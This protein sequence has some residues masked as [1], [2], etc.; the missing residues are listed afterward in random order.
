[1]K[2]TV[3]FDKDKA[4]DKFHTGWGVSY[5]IDGKVL[6][7]AGERGDFILNNLKYLNIDTGRITRVVISHN[8]WD[9]H[10]G[11]LDLLN[12]NGDIA[13]F[14]CADFYRAYKSKFP[15]YNFKLVEGLQEIEKNIYTTG[16][17]STPYKGSSLSEQALILRTNKGISL[18]CGCSHPGVWE[19][20]NKVKLE[21]GSETIYSV[22][23]GFHLM[24]KDKRVVNYLAQELKQAG[25]KNVGPAHCT[26]FEAVNIFKSVFAGNVL[27]VKVGLEINL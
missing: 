8:H 10:S 15:E 22:L 16:C 19:F 7:D 12:L 20:V 25:V 5:L 1:M 14:G 21:F 24:D 17:F 2:F 13:V 27:D 18:I 9:H 26:G 4:E 11:L 3:I 6:F 23:G